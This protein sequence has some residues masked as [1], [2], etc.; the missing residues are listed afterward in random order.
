M[1]RMANAGGHL[2]DAAVPVLS[3]FLRSRNRPAPDKDVAS[4]AVFTVKTQ[5]LPFVQTSDLIL[6]PKQASN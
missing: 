5:Q 1:T 2:L 4:L 6:S 3:C